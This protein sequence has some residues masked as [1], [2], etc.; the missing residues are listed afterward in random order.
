MDRKS[1]VSKRLFGKIAV[2]TG[3]A[4]G[5]GEGI[6]CEF[7]SQ[8]AS[9]IIADIDNGKAKY[10]LSK[11]KKCG[12]RAMFLK[13][14][15]R[16]RKIVEETVKDVL[17]QFGTID[18]L[19][20]CAG[21]DRFRFA[22]EFSVEEWEWIMSVNLDG[23]WHF[24]QAVLPVMMRK[25]KGKIINIGSVSA[26]MARPMG[27]PYVISKHGI[28]GLTKALAV[29]MGPY[30][31]NVNCICPASVDTPLLRKAGKTYRE[32]MIN[33]IPLGRVGRIRDIAKAAL[34]LASGDADWITGIIL[35]VDG[36]LSCCSIAHRPE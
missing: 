1:A 22:H 23:A 6:C 20:N 26:I 17:N 24:C 34:F 35:P 14:D 25:R 4:S 2:V 3:G 31:I 32:G 29:D 10:I 7:A 19:V 27:A 28:A 9:V 21:V 16:D 11:I 12:E 5:I 13:T 33:R 36:G 18:I 15:I 30:N 8:G